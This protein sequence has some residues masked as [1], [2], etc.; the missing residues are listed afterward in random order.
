MEEQWDRWQAYDFGTGA[1]I[2]GA[3][4]ARIDGSYRRQVRVP[5]TNRL[6]VG[7]REGEIFYCRTR[8]GL[9]SETVLALVPFAPVWALP[10]DPA[11]ADKRRARVVQLDLA[12]PNSANDCGSSSG[13][14]VSS[15]VAWTA[16]INNARRRQ[17]PLA[18]QSEEATKLWRRYCTTAKRLWRE[19]R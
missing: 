9:R 14:T 16:A 4:I 13:K 7:S 11:H 18:D 8:D 2:C 17:L 3:G 1:A 15:L 6:L 12:E 10:S 19:M 5:A